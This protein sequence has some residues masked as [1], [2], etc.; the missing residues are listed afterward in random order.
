LDICPV[1]SVA[2]RVGL[3]QT[4]NL[5]DVQDFSC[6][7]A[8]YGLVSK[9]EL[10]PVPAAENSV[11]LEPVDAAGGEVRADV[12]MRADGTLR[13]VA[14][15]LAWDE[16]V[17]RPIGSVPG[18]FLQAQDGVTL[19][20]APGG[21]DYAVLGARDLGLAGEGVMAS[22]RFRR[23]GAGDPHLR[24]ETV[25]GVDLSGNL[26]QVATSEPSDAGTPPR[27]T[28][29][30]GGVPN[31]FNP[32]T[33]ITYAVAGR[34]SIRLSIY[35]LDGRLVREL[36][37]GERDAGTYDVTWDGTDQRGA[38]VASGVYY[39]RF[40]AADGTWSKPLVLVK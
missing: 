16:S 29:L 10:R 23:V 34:Q 15:Q 14:V 20:P 9:S 7:A 2:P 13:A 39:A 31:P 11:R 26:A 33:R 32:S 12:H 4:D 22:V 30:L 37:R 19:E 6:L 24:I 8:N 40:A 17:V 28:A 27:A 21:V 5:I 38:R 18:A 25:R 36:A 35:S 3:P 1:Y